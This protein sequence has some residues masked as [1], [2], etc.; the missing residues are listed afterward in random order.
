M[1]AVKQYSQSN[2]TITTTEHRHFPLF[3]CLFMD[4]ESPLEVVRAAKVC[5]SVIRWDHTNCVE[6]LEEKRTW[7]LLKAEIGG[8]H[9]RAMDFV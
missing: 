3:L 1:V 9:T 2:T 6:E 5:Y 4:R 8:R 7:S